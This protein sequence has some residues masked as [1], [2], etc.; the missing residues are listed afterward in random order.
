[1]SD[2]AMLPNVKA[3]AKLNVT[4]RTLFHGPRIHELDFQHR[5][6]SI[7]GDIIVEA[8]IIAW[9]EKHTRLHDDVDTEVVAEHPVL[10]VAES[11]G[12]RRT[13]T[14]PG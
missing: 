9:Q 3:A 5:S 7:S 10:M 4:V 13:S 6:S 14:D 1:M 8:E 11:M 12:R 2:T